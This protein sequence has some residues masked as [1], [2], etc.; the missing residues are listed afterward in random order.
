MKLICKSRL[1]FLVLTTHLIGRCKKG[2]FEVTQ[3]RINYDNPDAI[4]YGSR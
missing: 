3:V 1:E 4:H 2:Y